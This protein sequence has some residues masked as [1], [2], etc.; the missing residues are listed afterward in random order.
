M[1]S[2][3]QQASVRLQ[4]ILDSTRAEDRQLLDEVT[5]RADGLENQLKLEKATVEQLKHSLK[6]INDKEKIQK[7]ELLK[8]NSL[9][10]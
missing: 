1:V 4:L 7:I 5:R 2:D 3:V 9:V 8:V 10:V 6:E